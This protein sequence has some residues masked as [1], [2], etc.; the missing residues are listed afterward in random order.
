[1]EVEN[2]NIDYNNKILAIKA[3]GSSKTLIESADLLG[4]T[5]PTMYNWMKIYKIY[6]DGE[7]KIT[8]DNFNIKDNNKK[9]VIKALDRTKT[10]KEAADLIGISKW[11][12]YNWMKLYN[13]PI[14][15]NR[16]VSIRRRKKTNNI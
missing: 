5:L 4:I 10:Y 12:L 8:K 7:C 6:F 9:L 16:V 13:I 11:T 2:L 15:E 14:D 3:L 1:M